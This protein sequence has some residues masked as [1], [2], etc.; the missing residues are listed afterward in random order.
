[1][2]VDMRPGGAVRAVS[3]TLAVLTF[4][5]VGNVGSASATTTDLVLY[6]PFEPPAAASSTTQPFLGNDGDGAVDTSV[7]ESSGG[8]LTSVSSR[9][10]QGQAVRFPAFDPSEYGARAVVR[11][12]N[13]TSTDV[14]APGRRNFAWS[15]AFKIDAESAEHSRTSHDNGDNLLQRGLY[16]GPQFKLDVDDHRPGCRLRG[17][18]GGSGAVRVVSAVTVSA[19]RWYRATCT[20]S[21]NRLTIK[22]TLFAADGSVT[23][24]WRRSAT[25]KVGFGK[26]SWRNI[27][28]PVTIGGKLTPSSTTSTSSDQFN[29]VVDNPQLRIWNP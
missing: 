8:T 1:M 6:Y 17:S 7:V 26:L 21:G 2:T 25:S 10:G 16:Y 23:R 19:N 24:S 12:V 14:L 11:I 3:A 15:A 28:T 9:P 22:L 18:T 4:S 27:D 29:G 20:R 5:V 13:R